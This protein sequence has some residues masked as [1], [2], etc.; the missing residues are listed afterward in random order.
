[1]D[2]VLVCQGGLFEVTGVGEV[3]CTGTWGVVDVTAVTRP[4][5]F[6]LEAM[7]PAV[8]AEAF[9]AGFV[10]VGSVLL[11]SWGCRLLIAAVRRG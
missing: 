5:A 1:M 6:T 8:L 3:S 7:D 9:S 4:E 11:V 10:L 2:S